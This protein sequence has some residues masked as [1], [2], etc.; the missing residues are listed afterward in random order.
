VEGW[1][2]F[3][4][5]VRARP[6]PELGDA[7][8]TRI[9][10]VGVKTPERYT[11]VACVVRSD[12]NGQKMLAFNEDAEDSPEQMGLFSRDVETEE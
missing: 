9:G 6:K 10:T 12:R 11:T 5:K 2:E 1:R 8:E 7:I 3:S 4:I